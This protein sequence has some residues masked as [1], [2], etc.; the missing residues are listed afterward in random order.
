MSAST[1][2]YTERVTAFIGSELLGGQDE[3][4]DPTTPLLELG[5]LDSFSTIKLL[6]FVEDELGITVPLEEVTAEN[7]ASIE[8]FVECLV[9]YAD[10]SA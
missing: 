4:L 2:R 1:Q 5:I 6:S 9:R 10:E 7:L 3:G 8:S